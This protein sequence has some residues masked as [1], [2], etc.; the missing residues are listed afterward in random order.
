M[1]S[2]GTI[3]RVINIY[4]NVKFI[5]LSLHLLAHNIVILSYFQQE[6]SEDQTH[7]DFRLWLTSYPTPIF[8]V[9]ILRNGVKMTNEAPK[10][11]RF[12]IIKSYKSDPISDPEFFNGCKQPVSSNVLCFLFHKLSRVIFVNNSDECGPYAKIFLLNHHIIGYQRNYL[13][14]TGQSGTDVHIQVLHRP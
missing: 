7:P 10:G 5:Y 13:S 9:S 2:F 1:N 12:N 11:L 6:L 3:G 8:P 14:P 4:P